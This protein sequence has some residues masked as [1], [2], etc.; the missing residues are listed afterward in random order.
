VKRRD[1]N[2]DHD[3]DDDAIV[4]YFIVT[5]EGKFR[6]SG[7]VNLH[8]LRTVDRENPYESLDHEGT[9]P[10]LVSLAVDSTAWIRRSCA[11]TDHEILCSM[12]KAFEY[13][14]YVA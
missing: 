3:G 7:Q 11:K 13:R 10:K 2:L 1:S 8:N 5:E 12:W 4:K 6:L 9:I 14:F